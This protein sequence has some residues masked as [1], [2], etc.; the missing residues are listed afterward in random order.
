MIPQSIHW[1]LICIHKF[2][3]LAVFAVLTAETVAV[4]RLLTLA[5]EKRIGGRIIADSAARTFDS[6]RRGWESKSRK[7]CL[8]VCVVVDGRRIQQQ[9]LQWFSPES[10]CSPAFRGRT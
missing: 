4:R 7:T 3:C 1:C 5:G 8:E 6:S 9:G 2:G 10:R